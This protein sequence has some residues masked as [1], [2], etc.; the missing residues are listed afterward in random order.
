V[1]GCRDVVAD[2]RLRDLQALLVRVAEGNYGAR[3]SVTPDGDE[4]DALSVGINLLAEQLAYEQLQR[5]EAERALER[6]RAARRT[7]E[8][9]KMRA[10]ATL[11]GGVA[12]DMN[13]LLAVGMAVSGALRRGGPELPDEPLADLDLAL[14][15]AAALVRQLLA[16]SIDAVDHLPADP[17]AALRRAVRL[18]RRASSASVTMSSDLPVEL[19]RVPIDPADLERAVVNLCTNALEAMPDGGRLEVVVAHRVEAAELQISVEDT[20]CGMDARTLS[21]AT[22]PLFTTKAEGHGFGLALAYSMCRRAGGDLAIRS[23]VGQGTCVDLILPTVP[24][25]R[26]ACQESS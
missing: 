3:A 1:P 12:H 8:H 17:S 4:I 21:R 5:Q 18:A 2:P 6:A 25:E 23:A 24:G 16:V 9:Q 26:M 7:V 10:L 11:C 20:G 19:P 14:T 13:N 15:Q 22:E